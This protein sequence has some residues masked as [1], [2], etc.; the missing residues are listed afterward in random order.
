MKKQEFDVALGRRKRNNPIGRLIITLFSVLLLIFFTKEIPGQSSTGEISITVSD[1][2]NALVVGAAVTIKGSNTGNVVRKL[3]T[4]GQG[5]ATGSLLPPG[6]YDVTVSAK[7]FKQ[8][9]QPQIPVHVG[10]TTGLRIQLETGSIEETVTVSGSAPLIEDKTSTL[11]QVISEERMLTVPLN[12]RSY[13]TVANLSPGAVPTVGAKDSSFS[14][15][16]NSGLQNAFLL[17]GARNVSY[18]RGLDNAQR[19]VVR[20][21]LDALA[22]FSVQTSN[23]SSEYGDSA[24][25]VINAITKSGTNDIHG[26]T[27]EFLQN[28]DMNAANYFALAGQ[29]PLLVQNQYGVS[30]GAPIKRD[31][32]WIF[33]A[34]ERVSNH[35]DVVSKSSVPSLANRA[36]NFG[37]TPI[38]DPSTTTPSGSGYTRTLFPN[39]TI[40]STS[41]STITAQ[42]LNNYPVP[43]VPGSATLFV[44]NAPQV[45]TINNGVG[46]ADLQITS[47]DS[48]FVRGSMD[49][50]SLLAAAALPPPTNTPVLRTIKSDG[51]G[52][53]YTR[54]VSPTSVNEAR[55]AWTRIDL[56]SNATQAL[57]AIIPG[58]L[59]SGI[60]SSTPQFNISGLATIGAQAGC[61]TNTPLHKSVGV[62]DFSDNFSKMVKR[63]SLKVGGEM[64]LIRPSTQAALNGRGVFGFTGVFSQN[65]QGRAGT[66]SAVADFLLGDANTLVTGSILQDEERAWYAGGYVQDDWTVN[67]SLTLNLGGRYEYIAPSVETNNK[68]ANFIS[69]PNEPNFGSYILAGD[70][71]YPRS[72]VTA[73][74][75]EFAPRVGF[76]YRTPFVKDLVVRGS[77]GIFHAQDNGIGV[78]SRLTANPPFY[79]Y[80]GLSIV[81]DQVNPSSG[82]QVVPGATITP[83]TPIAPSQFKL[84]PLSTT[85]LQ[86]WA[87]HMSQPYVEEWNLTIQKLVP[88]KMAWETSYVGNLGVHM[89]NNMQGNQPLT[90]GPGSPNTRRPLAAFTVASINL[91]TPWGTSSYEGVSTKL[92]KKMDSGVSFLASLTYGRTIDLQDPSAQ[93]CLGSSGCGG[94]GD[95]VQNVY[96]VRAQRG[97]SDNNVPLRFSLG[98]EWALP[99][100]RGNA[101]LTTG[102]SS[103]IAGGWSLAGIYQSQSGMPFT[104]ILS[105]DNANAGNTSWPN[106]ICNGNISHPTVSA[107][108]NTSCFVTPPQYQFGNTGRNVL[109]AGRVNNLDL[110]IH[111]EFSVPI[112]RETRLQFR[113]E[114]F[115]AMNHPQFAQP[116]SSLGTST[117]G[118][119]TATSQAN[120]VLQLGARLAF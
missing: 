117:F 58:S 66:G 44:Y 114:A 82:F 48:M 73:S 81:S 39:N 21:P 14:S 7:G 60:D 22:E 93:A 25:A 42:L 86:S 11:A 90:N 74:K 95:P 72:L 8:S 103:S 75:L 59:G 43:N 108:F 69:Q 41:F 94:G 19:D 2:A 89:W 46:R 47:K 34:Y 101:H 4:S 54:I 118:V 20:P 113:A 32:A 99:F 105:S 98:G 104:P 109:L 36:G 53:G 49:W 15:Y 119:V 31:R 84:N 63:H 5:L 87:S 17:D 67:S 116:G 29:K 62:W 51:I 111:R 106:R 12:G 64:M 1:A 78:S 23:Y 28:S 80:G 68:Q 96:N 50:Q 33:G 85:T 107:W 92:E 56:Q 52:Y 3:E 70:P 13:L 79:S 65:P 61:C 110:S 76:A 55:F 57:N 18:L 9:N 40:P 102:L 112:M 27:Y 16:G 77:F 83:P 100:G 97:P 91:S 6:T 10:Q 88:W 37:S 115:N 38:Y 45:S 71:R 24:G 35:T 30:L 26:S 120:R